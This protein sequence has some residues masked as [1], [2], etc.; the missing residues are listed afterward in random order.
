MSAAIAAADVGA[1]VTLID[2]NPLGGGQV[3]RAEP[4]E[5]R[6]ANAGKQ[7]PDQ[8][9]GGELRAALAA[10][11]A[12]CLFRHT[13]WN[14]S[15]GFRVD[16]VGP[17][18]P[19]ACWARA[20]IVAT[21]ATERVIP[22]PGWTAPGVIG[23][24]AATILLKSQRV[25]PGRSAVVAGCGPLLIAVAAGIVKGGGTVRAVIDIS[26]WSDWVSALPALSSRPHLLARGLQWLYELR[27]ARIP[28]LRRRTV[29]SALKTDSG[30]VVTLGPV[31]KDGAPSLGRHQQLHADCLAVGH[32]LVPGNEV[33]RI[34]RAEHRYSRELGGWVARTDESGETTVPSLFVAGDGAGIAGADAAAVHGRIAGLAAAHRIGKLGMPDFT[35]QAKALRLELKR[36]RR[37]GDAMAKLMALRPALVASIAPETVVCR[38][39]DITRGEVEGAITDGA[40]NLN[41][42]KAWTR[43]GMGP[44][45]GRSCGDILGEIVA[46]RVEG[47]RDGA[48]FFTGRPPLRPIRLGDLTGQYD[49]SHIPIPKAAPL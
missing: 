35:A 13:A 28:I 15:P 12:N 7:T 39:E 46:Q 8:I 38:C 48:G 27:K 22:F 5:F 29:I 21:G 3:Y 40:G 32:G 20:L 17:D 19:V 25:L 18:G 37:F 43:C 4:Q 23:L 49:Y 16:A 33:T 10:S 45:Q 42:V 30:L 24:A 14:V 44:C 41:Q 9:V 2:E 26:G 11:R 47:G 6:S 31:G 36:T 34:L 1:S